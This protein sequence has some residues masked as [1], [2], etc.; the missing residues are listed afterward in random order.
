MILLFASLAAA[1]KVEESVQPDLSDPE[2]RL[3]TQLRVMDAMIEAG[4]TGQALDMARDI[5]EK[6]VDDVRLDVVQAR[7][8]DATGMHAE[9]RE[10]LEH[11][12]D[13]RP[14]TSAAWAQLGIIYA[15]D[16]DVKA[17]RSALE[18]AVKLAPKDGAIRNNYGWVLLA[19][20]QPE[21]AV[22]QL[23]A[24]LRLDPGNARTRNNLGFALARLKRDT[25]AL[26]AF[27]GA[28]T[29]QGRGEADAR[30]NFGV[31][32]EQRGERDSAIVQYQTALGAQPDHPLA[33]AALA[34]LLNPEST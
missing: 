4:M 19:A 28:A 21:Q 5:R 18:R 11:A 12:V 34:R 20:G 29:A 33:K 8:M 23:Q 3:T 1:A 30:Y 24:A 6:G 16:D 9:A 2:V 31:A 22:T 13:R 25:E 7:A 15:D 17:A 32:C 26:E 14:R 10:L 27:R